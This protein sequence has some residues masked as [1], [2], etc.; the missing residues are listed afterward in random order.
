MNF[1]KQ[2]NFLKFLTII[3]PVSII[4]NSFILDLYK[5]IPPKEIL[6]RSASLVRK[7]KSGTA[8]GGINL[9]VH[10]PFCS[11]LCSYCHCSKCLLTKPE[12][13][14]EFQKSLIRQMEF[15]SCVFKDIEMSSLYFGGGTPSILSVPVLDNIFSSLHKNF[16]F[17]KNIQINFEAHPSSLPPRKIRLLK[18]YG[19]NRI[20]LGVQALNKT[21]LKEINRTQDEKTVI[22]AIENIR[23]LNFTSIN[24]DL[25]A[26][27]PKQTAEIFIRDLKKIASLKP[28]WILRISSGKGTK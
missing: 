9:Y 12:Q 15:Y 21:V 22:K 2:I 24:V 20:S 1:N 26:G 8:P 11:E 27:L 17:K 5:K 7:I 4:Q 16:R 13:I 25:I 28:D 14:T 18:E 19:V 6:D 3:K 10:I 23:K